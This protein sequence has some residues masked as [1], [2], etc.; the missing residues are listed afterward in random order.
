MAVLNDGTVLEKTFVIINVAA[1]NVISLVS[2]K[3]TQFYFD[4]GQPTLTATVI[5]NGT[6][7]SNSCTYKWIKI[8]SN[9]DYSILNQTGRKLQVSIKDIE[10]FAIFKCGIYYSNLYIGTA[11]I[12]LTNI[13]ET[14]GTY[15][16]A[17][18]NGSQIFIYDEAGIA[19]TSELNKNPMVLLPLSFDIYDNLGNY[20]EEDVLKQCSVQWAVP[21]TNTML[22]STITPKAT[23][24]K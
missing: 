8:D 21:I 12:T 20:L 4:Q 1:N 2:D 7:V 19:P 24:D 22:S 10:N 15:N 18:N 14:E 17:I 16:L 5:N 23:D 11:E 3:G 13:L 9:N 6:D